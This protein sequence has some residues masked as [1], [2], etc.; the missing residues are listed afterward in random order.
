MAK[1]LPLDQRISFAD[2]VVNNISQKSPELVDRVKAWREA[3]LNELANSFQSPAA[4]DV[5]GLMLLTDR[6]GYTSCAEK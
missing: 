5:A 6:L 2:Q 3:K 4:H 1:G